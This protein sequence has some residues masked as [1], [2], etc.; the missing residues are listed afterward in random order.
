MTMA[1]GKFL[2][3]FRPKR[4]KKVARN[5]GFT[6]IELLVAMVIA[7]IIVSTL[8]GFL[9]NILQGDRREQA[10]VDS[11][12]EL[13]SALDYIANDLQES[14]YIYDADGI[15][16]INA[17]LPHVQAGQ[18]DRVPVL[19]FWKRNYLAKED[20]V[21]TKKDG[22]AIRKVKCLLHPIATATADCKGSDQL[23]FSLVI[24]YLIKNDSSGTTWSNTARI[25]RIEFNDGIAAPNP[26]GAPTV[27]RGGTDTTPYLVVPDIGF[28]RFNV[29]DATDVTDA[30]KKWTKY[31]NY[32]L[33]KNQVETLIDYV[34][35][36]DA[37]VIASS[38]G[39][40]STEAQLTNN[41]PASGS[42][43][44][45]NTACDDP[46]RGVG[47]NDVNAG[48]V[49]QTIFAQRVPASFSTTAGNVTNFSSFFACVNSRQSVARVF[50]R[51]NALARIVSDSSQRVPN[52]SNT[53]F[54]PKGDV[55]AFGRGLININ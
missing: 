29:G 5:M 3:Q 2:R 24:Y 49:N 39:V 45:K 41:T 55:R 43:P 51:G 40:Q 8:L 31:A 15:A 1:I 20:D 50:I 12:Q 16:A 36:S 13:Q 38:F 52:S 42:T 11:Q 37:S 10:K 22:S 14:V 33:T 35:D 25:G 46:A 53:T 6:L 7:S 9:V 34:D 19:V 47:I 28:R 21:D 4:H 18:T 17:Q 44:S 32:D 30:M 26:T 23:V 27:L 48:G 54:F